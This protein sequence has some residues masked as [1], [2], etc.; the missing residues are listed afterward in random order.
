MRR[1][2][3]VCLKR[4]ATRFKVCDECAR[5]NDTSTGDRLTAPQ[6]REAPKAELPLT[7]RFGVVR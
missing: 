6:R 1:R 3:L 2:C 7:Y 4:P 5:A